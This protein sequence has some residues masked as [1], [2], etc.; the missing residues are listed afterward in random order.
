MRSSEPH[1]MRVISKKKKKKKSKKREH[2]EE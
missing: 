2:G 1:G